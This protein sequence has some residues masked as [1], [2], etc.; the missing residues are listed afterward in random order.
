MPRTKRSALT[1]AGLVAG[2]ALLLAAAASPRGIKAGGTF[3]IATVG[4]GAIDP[5]FLRDRVLDPSCGSLVSF[6]D[7]P[8][9]RGFT[10]EP[11][12]AVAMPTASGDGRTYTFTV[13]KDA[14]FSDGTRVTARAFS[15]A[16][17]RIFTPAMETGGAELDDIV[18]AK[19]MLDGKATTLSGAIA[20][21]RTLTLRLTKRSPAFLLFM[22]GLCAVPPNLPADPEGAGAPLHSPAAYYVSRYVPGEGAVM[23]RNRFYRGDRPGH[24]DRFVIDGVSG[25]TIDLA[26]K[27][28]VEMAFPNATEWGAR[29]AELGRRYGV[30]RSQFWVKPGAGLRLLVLNTSRPL[31]RKNPKLRQAVNFAVDR[32]ALTKELGAYA[33]T[34]TDQYL[35]PV[36]R[37]FRNELIYPLH[38][39]DL[40]RARELAKGHLRFGKAVLYTPSFTVPMSVSQV[41]KRNLEAI[42]LDVEIRSFPPA[43][44]FAK[45]ATPGERFDIGYIGWFDFGTRDPSFLNFL[46]DGEEGFGNYSYFNSPKVNRQLDAAGSLPG[47]RRNRAYGKLDVEISRDF[48]P[49]IPYAAINVATFVSSKVG[50]IVV[51]PDLD[52]DVVCLK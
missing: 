5:A 39:P 18:G 42:G 26:A 22:T 13:R 9:P 44:S 37:G 31:F 36:M 24:I 45:I 27:G 43:V 21:D 33:G 40:D 28:D 10:V 51:N 12:L 35:L 19:E 11:D 46:F 14:R 38:G 50:C 23:E 25:S 41:A 3:R 1:L 30:N 52:L 4:L 8:L 16:L 49:A 7:E 15:R 34:A 47:L 32:K 20:R 17:E 29:S 2:A 48:A 6:R